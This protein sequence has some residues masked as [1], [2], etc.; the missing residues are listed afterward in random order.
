[1]KLVDYLLEGR[2]CDVDIF[3]GRA[4]GKELNALVEN[5]LNVIQEFK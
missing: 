2:V 1:M 4:V 3:K 5:D